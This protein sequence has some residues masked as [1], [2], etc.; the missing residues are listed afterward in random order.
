[1]KTGLNQLRS[2]EFFPPYRAAQ[3]AHISSFA[4][5]RLTG[6]V[7]VAVEKPRKQSKKHHRIKKPDGEGSLSGSESSESSVEDFP[8]LEPEIQKLNIGLDMKFN[9]TNMEVRGYTSKRDGQWCYSAN[10]IKLVNGNDYPCYNVTT[11]FYNYSSS[12]FY[13]V[14]YYSS[15]IR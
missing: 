11:S 5:S 7:L 3:M 6:R 12:R 1:M 14:I 9:K 10:A 13:F 15:R 8:A 4:L 2:Q